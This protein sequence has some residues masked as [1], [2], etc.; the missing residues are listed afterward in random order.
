MDIYETLI[1]RSGSDRIILSN[2]GKHFLGEL[3]KMFFDCFE[4]FEDWSGGAHLYT[5]LQRRRAHCSMASWWHLP[6]YSQVLEDFHTLWKASIYFGS[7]RRQCAHPCRQKKR[8]AELKKPDHVST[9][10]ERLAQRQRREKHSVTMTSWGHSGSSQWKGKT[11]P[12]V[13]GCSVGREQA[14]PEA[15]KSKKGFPKHKCWFRKTGTF[16]VPKNGGQRSAT[17][18]WV[19]LRCPPFSGTK[20]VP[21]TGTKFF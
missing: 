13:S 6:L 19:A 17:N 3:L 14:I 11:Q 9:S 16:L 8:F 5:G 18:G 2:F 4:T 21:K 1:G 7:L 15:P 12:I 10:D 20:S